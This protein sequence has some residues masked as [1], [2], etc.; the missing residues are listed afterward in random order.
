MIRL[1]IGHAKRRRNDSKIDVLVA[2][3]KSNLD[4]KTLRPGNIE[5]IDNI[6]ELNAFY[7]LL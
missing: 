7:F 5:K 2:S 6:I 3:T 4:Y 1:V